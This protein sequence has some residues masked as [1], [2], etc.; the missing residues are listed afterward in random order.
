MI[1]VLPDQ[2]ASQIAAGEVV[3]R[4]SSVVKE[5]V[6]NSID[7]GATTITIDIRGGGRQLI[8]V[9]DNGSGIDTAEIE[10][11]FLRHAT[12]KL[13]TAEDLHA[14][15]TLGFRGEALA[16]IAA[17]SQVTV[18]SRARDAATGTRLVL[19]GGHVVTRE[20]VGAPAGTV[21]AVENLFYNVPARLKFLKSIT[22]EKRLIDEF[23]TRYAL[24]YPAIRFR[25]T[26]DNRV[27][28]QTT[29]NGQTADVLLAVYG[30]DTVRQLISVAPDA[31]DERPVRV[32]GYVSDPALNW[33]NRNHIQLFVNGRAVRDNRLTFAVVQ[34][35]HTLLPAGRYPLGLLFLTLPPEDVDVNVHPA[36]VEVRFRD[37]GVMFSAVQREVRAV[38]LNTT[39]G[40]A[41]G[42]GWAMVGDSWSAGGGWRV[43]G[44]DR[45]GFA[46]RDDDG[47]RP[48]AQ[49]DIP[50]QL[51]PPAPETGIGD[52]PATPV[53]TPPISPT[54][55]PIMRVVGQVGAAYIIAEGP[56]GLY[57]I[58]QHAAHE[59]ILYEQL[60]AQWRQRH[61]ASQGLVAPAT[62][63]LSPSQADLVEEHAALLAGLGFDVEPFGPGAFLVRAVPA[64]LGRADP[65]AALSAVV[66][67]LESA[68]TPLQAQLEALA[69]RRVCKSAAVKAGQTLSREEMEALIAQLERCETPHTCPHGRPTLIHLSAAALARQFGRT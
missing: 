30:P 27:T 64:L 35:Y 9:A 50:W 60:L 46:S 11:A 13:N 15:R 1:H 19:D 8:Q 5:L 69:L 28:F 2:L 20:A 54:R 44:G 63:Y 52:E 58:D 56:D 33:A 39:P 3:E 6:E 61:V 16:A 40:R 29:G 43:A 12:S 25:L 32:R 14:I 59:R 57:L 68:A 4:P 62:V 51:Q 10:T 24:A 45:A 22:T 18:V 36:K 26:H 53:A 67:D 21:I 55:L 34:A 41:V 65:A 38:L 42:G 17:V 37:E 47:E 23:V 48:A 31:S 66:A 49:L 7:A